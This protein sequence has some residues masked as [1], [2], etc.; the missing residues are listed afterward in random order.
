MTSADPVSPREPKDAVS[1]R[2]LFQA[3]RR[4]PVLFV[5]L[6]LLTAATGVG[7]WWALPLP[8]HTAAVVFQVAAQPPAVLAPTSDSRVDFPAYRQTQAALV[9]K[10]Q[11]LAAA[12]ESPEV[13]DL[14]DVREQADPV[15]WL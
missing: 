2:L 11:V 10:R 8:R 15:T 13:R 5:G 1:G 4:H 12:L 6:V 7:L 3:V 14:P 9:K